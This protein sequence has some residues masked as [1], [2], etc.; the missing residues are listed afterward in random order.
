MN[1]T[2]LF[3]IFLVA[4]L[5]LATHDVLN[6]IDKTPEGKNLLDNL[7]IQT[8]LMGDSLDINVIRAFLKNNRDKVEAE[9]REVSARIEKRIGEC[10]AD[11][12]VGAALAEQHYNRQYALK[13]HVDA[14]GRAQKRVETLVSRANDEL[15]NYQ[16]FQNYIQEG[17][18]A[19]NNYF[20]A[21]SESFHSVIGIL[22]SVVSAAK[23]QQTA[24]SFLELSEE[25]HSNLAEM[26]VKI[27]STNLEYTGVSPIIS[28]LLEIMAD[29]NA[30]A[31]PEVRNSIRV[32][33]EGLIDHVRD[34][35]DE[36][37]EQHEHQSA[38]FSNL[39]KAY[40]DNTDRTQ[41]EVEGLN[42]QLKNVNGRFSTLSTAHTHA[43][44]LTN[45]VNNI[46]LLRGK[47]CEDYRNSKNTAVISTDKAT[48]VINQIEEILTDKAAGIKTF[49]LQRE[50]RNS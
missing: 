21:A 23:S 32:L 26:K 12:K 10:E 42:E 30:A 25:Y 49:F 36:I 2:T 1:K 40:K 39:V 34:R 18:D 27:Q 46:I 3:I 6:M 28:N 29:P 48:A 4:P 22:N 20:N 37:E 7:F 19:W 33:A 31:K 17:V 38:L 5:I 14:A 50:M 35:L 45:K 9:R 24:T 13:R 41:K 15:N 44:Q 8:K 47:E 16:K 43:T 11:E